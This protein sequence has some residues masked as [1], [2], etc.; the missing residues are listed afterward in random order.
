MLRIDKVPIFEASP[1]LVGQM[2]GWVDVMPSDEEGS[3][4]NVVAGHATVSVDGARMQALYASQSDTGD[5]PT[6]LEDINTGFIGGTAVSIY[7]KNPNVFEC[8]NV[9]SSVPLPGAGPR[10]RDSLFGGFHREEKPDVGQGIWAVGEGNIV[11]AIKKALKQVGAQEMYPAVYYN[12]A[13]RAE[14][15]LADTTMQDTTRE[16]FSIVDGQVADINEML[17]LDTLMKKSLTVFGEHPGSRVPSVFAESREKVGRLERELDKRSKF[18]T[19]GWILP[20]GFRPGGRTWPYMDSMNEDPE[21]SYG[22][23]LD[24][25]K[26]GNID[27]AYN[28]LGREIVELGQRLELVKVF[29]NALSI[30]GLKEQHLADIGDI[31][32][33]FE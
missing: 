2:V 19:R 33:D 26:K 3:L 15:P 13:I 24:E 18:Y 20:V 16:V 10:I 31:S 22:P 8:V 32:P 14:K 5:L 29:H 17:A 12:L 11:G 21:R 6:R 1:E 27:R 23:E 25:L 28:E 9:Q 30:L 7:F 4:V